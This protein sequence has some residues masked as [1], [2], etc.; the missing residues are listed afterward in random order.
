[1]VGDV[2]DFDRYAQ[3]IVGTPGKQD[4]LAWHNP[5]G[6]WGGPAGENTVA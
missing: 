6:A 3:R 4:G 2:G 1:M 5:G